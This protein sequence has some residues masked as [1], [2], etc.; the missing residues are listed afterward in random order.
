MTKQLIDIAEEQGAI[1]LMVDDPYF[2]FNKGNIIFENIAQLQATINAYNAQ[3]SEP[4]AYR[5]HIEHTK[6]GITSH[7]FGYSDIQIMQGDDALYLA[8]QTIPP[9][10]AEY[11]ERIENALNIIVLSEEPNHVADMLSTKGMA[12]TAKQALATKPKG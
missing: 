7:E 6:D 3:N 1:K 5:Q 2:P 9:E 4:V 10:W 8:P 12:I 11:M